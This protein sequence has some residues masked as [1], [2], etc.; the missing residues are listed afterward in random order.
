MLHNDSSHQGRRNLVGANKIQCSSRN[1][2]G[3]SKFRPCSLLNSLIKIFHA[4]FSTRY[5]MDQI[6]VFFCRTI[7]ETNCIAH[8]IPDSVEGQEKHFTFLS[9]LDKN[10][11]QT[12]HRVFSLMFF[13]SRKSL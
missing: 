4:Q 5:G 2:M 6:L 12:D 11:R 9:L 13:L 10:I 8:H 3:S 7:F 1:P